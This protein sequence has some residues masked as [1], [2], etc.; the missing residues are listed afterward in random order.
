MTKLWLIT[1]TKKHSKSS[2]TWRI[3]LIAWTT[4]FVTKRTIKKRMIGSTCLISSW[5][6]S[7]MSARWCS[8]ICSYS[9][10]NTCQTCMLGVISI[11]S[12]Q[13]LFRI[14][15]IRL[16]VI[17]ISRLKS[18]ISFSWI[19]V[20]LWRMNISSLISNNWNSILSLWTLM[21]WISTLNTYSIK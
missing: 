19:Y 4:L 11:F 1:W 7:L 20:L 21:Q 12:R 15:S 9:T 6:A 8:P 3:C 2:K 5:T 10:K 13:S 18:W 14:D 17:Q 16:I